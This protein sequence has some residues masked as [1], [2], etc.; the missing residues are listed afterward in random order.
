MLSHAAIS[1]IVSCPMPSQHEKIVLGHFILQACLW[2]TR[3][4]L[5][6]P[7]WGDLFEEGFV[8]DASVAIAAS[9]SLCAWPVVDK[10]AG[11]E[12]S[13]IHRA[14]DWQT[15]SQLPWGVVLLLGGGFALAAAFESSGLSS[16]ISSELLSGATVQGLGAASLWLLIFAI[17][18][19]MSGLT[20]F[21]SNVATVQVALP[22][23]AGLSRQGRLPPAVLM[24]PATCATSFAFM[25]PV[26][27][28]AN[29]IAVSSGAAVGLKVADM[30]LPGLLVNGLAV[31][32]TAVFSVSW[33][34]I[35]F[36]SEV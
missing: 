8:T 22:L 23:L 28:P 5:I 10:S 34:P 29:A 27:T 11:R 3:Q 7:G 30:A 21:T 24:V 18:A 33:G 14:L 17:C 25:L 20:E 31:L 26:A 19:L 16:W 1:M 32:T 4:P 2:F 9:L 12:C 6:V 13:G 36:G 35:V 15:A